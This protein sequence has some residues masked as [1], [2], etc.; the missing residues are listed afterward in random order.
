MKTRFPIITNACS[1][2]IV[3]L[4]TFY[5]AF[6]SCECY[7]SCSFAAFDAH[8]SQAGLQLGHVHLPILVGV[9]PGEQILVRLGAIVGAPALREKQLPHDLIH[10]G[11]VGVER[12]KLKENF[13]L[14][15]PE[16]TRTERGSC[17]GKHTPISDAGT[18]GLQQ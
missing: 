12:A 10:G 14:Q 16:Q 5:Q 1:Q 11:G 3:F 2:R 8:R 13:G 9:Q 4:S 18:S 15:S 6:L 17:C 7:L